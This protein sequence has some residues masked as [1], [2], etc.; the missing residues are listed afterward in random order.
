[1]TSRLTQDQIIGRR[2]ISIEGDAPMHITLEGGAVLILEAYAYDEEDNEYAGT[3][4]SNIFQSS[5]FHDTENFS[6]Y[7]ISKHN[8][9]GGEDQWRA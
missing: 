6:D 8:F 1:M 5:K 3:I 9:K 4:V 7:L 2:I